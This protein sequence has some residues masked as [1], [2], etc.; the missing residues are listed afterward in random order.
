MLYIVRTFAEDIRWTREESLS[1]IVAVEFI[2]LP[3][4]DAEGAIETELNSKPG[5]E[6]TVE[7]NG[8]RK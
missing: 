4:S 1:K 8:F 2:D 5:N 6:N 3:L 7:T